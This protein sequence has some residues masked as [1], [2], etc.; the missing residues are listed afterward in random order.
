MAQAKAVDPSA[1]KFSLGEELSTE[2]E[3]RIRALAN[4][5]EEMPS[6]LCFKHCLR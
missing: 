5:R 1:V 4:V 2:A 3:A 6:E